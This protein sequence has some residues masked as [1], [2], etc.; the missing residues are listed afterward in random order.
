MEN[1]PLVSV[2]IPV[3]NRETHI[4]QCLEIVSNQSYQNLEI[5][6][7]NDGSS[8]GSVDIIKEF[9]NVILIEHEQNQGLSS[10][11]N[12]GIDNATGKY[13][14]FLDDDDQ[15][16]LRF[17]ERLVKAAEATNA[18]MTACGY[19]NQNDHCKTQLFTELQEHNTLQE[20]LIAT[21]VGK[22]GYVWRYLFKL[23]FIKEH[24][25][26]FEV[27][28]LIEDLP[29]SFLA[30]YHA[31]KLVTVPLA[32]YLYANTPN[33]IINTQDKQR[34]AKRNR[35]GA[36]AHNFVTQFALDHGGFKIPGVNTGK[37]AYVWRKIK[38]SINKQRDILTTD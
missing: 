35:D 20:R 13:I 11:R 2:I 10:A 28:R 33:S 17:Y 34:K 38:Y 4:R 24:N 36:Y 18:D 29:F 12:T 7:I 9:A 26:R 3:Y 37:L 5:I 15:I 23:D 22:W 30:V 25:L 16:N 19:I 1:Q 14:H 27:G 8:D 32:E 6:T 21:Y 31:N